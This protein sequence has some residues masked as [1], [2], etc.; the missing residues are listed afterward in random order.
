M[1]ILDKIVIQKKNHDKYLKQKI[2]KN[3]KIKKVKSKFI[4]SIKNQLNRGNNALIVEFKRFSPSVNK[5][6]NINYLQEIITQYQESKCCCISILTDRNFGGSLND[7]LIA[8][9]IT[10]KPI[11]RKDFI[12]NKSQILES[13]FYGA[14]AIL[15]IAKILTKKELSDLYKYAVKINLD[16]LIEIENESEIKKIDKINPKIIGIN[17]RDLR[18]QKIDI[19]KSIDLSK[20]LKNKIVIGES[21]ITDKNIKKIKTKSEIKSFLVGGSILNNNNR[22]NFINRLAKA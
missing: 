21:G 20:K 6:K 14:D 19:N 17:N 22:I 9:K 3:Q 18:K 10:S 4:Q 8:K 15:L 13:K 2:N 12:I 5:F 7:I 1:D 11:L 16:V